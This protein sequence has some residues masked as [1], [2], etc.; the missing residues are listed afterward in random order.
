MRA[1]AAP[2]LESRATAGPAAARARRNVGVGPVERNA[3]QV[4]VVGCKVLRGMDGE[5]RRG[6]RAEDQP[7]LSATSVAIRRLH[8]KNVGERRVV[9]CRHLISG[10]DRLGPRPVRTNLDPTHPA[11]TLFPVNVPGEQVVNAELAVIWSSD[12]GVWR[13]WF[14]SR[15]D[16]PESA[17]RR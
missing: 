16:E 2:K 1:D 8:F 6:R 7:Q 14:E 13:Y 12:F 17:K 9:R 3:T 5:L 15:S 11:R 10:T 4:C